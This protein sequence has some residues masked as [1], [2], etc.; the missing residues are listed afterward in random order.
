MEAAEAAQE[1]FVRAYFALGKLN[2][3][4]AFFSWLLGIADRVAKEAARARSRRK[5]VALRDDVA[6]PPPQRDDS[7]TEQLSSAVAGL[8]ELYRQ[9]VL[10]RYYADM[11]CADISRHLHVP[12]GTVTK[13]LSR[14]YALLRQTLRSPSDPQDA[15]VPS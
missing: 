15:E 5:N 8:P 1:T 14:A 9:V 7:A 11:S 13:R 2:R 3:P 6:E 10:L 4:E 12:V